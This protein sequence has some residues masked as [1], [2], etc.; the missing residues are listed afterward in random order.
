MGLYREPTLYLLQYGTFGHQPTLNEATLTI[1][2]QFFDVFHFMQSFFWLQK[3]T[4]EHHNQIFSTF[5]DVNAN[6]K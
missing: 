4:F 1:E 3:N 2:T 6:L 5:Y